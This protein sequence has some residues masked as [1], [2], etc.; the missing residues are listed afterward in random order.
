[1]RL[2][3]GLLISLVA[4]LIVCYAVTQYV[5]VARFWGNWTPAYFYN[6]FQDVRV[7]VSWWFRGN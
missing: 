4:S 3:F 1:M 7:Y 2:C 6:R 5:T